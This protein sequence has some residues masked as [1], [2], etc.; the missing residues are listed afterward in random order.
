VYASL[1]DIILLSHCW[2]T[3]HHLDARV[4]VTCACP[5]YSLYSTGEWQIVIHMSNSILLVRPVW[6]EI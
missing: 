3:T 1:V 5:L 6:T 2:Y 4:W